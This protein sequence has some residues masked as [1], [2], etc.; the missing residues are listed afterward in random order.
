MIPI[1]DDNPTRLTPY[2]TW[3]L[4]L[5][6]VGVYIWQVQQGPD[7]KVFIDYG[8]MPDKLMS[9]Q[10]GTDVPAVAPIL[11]IFTSMF[12]HGGIWH[13]LGNMLY[14]WIFGNNIEDAMG[15]ARFLLF[16]VLSG[17]AAAM[18][19]AMMDPASNIPMVGA[20]GAISGVLGAY[21]L[22]YPRARVTVL[23]PILIIL[24]PFRISAVWVV[25]VWFAMQLWNAA[26]SMPNSPGVAWWAHVGGFAAGIALTPFLKSAAIPFFGPRPT[27]GPWG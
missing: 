14:L 15:H 17:V 3:A 5:A 7:S 19:M 24:Y 6:C 23:I 16:Y 18:T 25:G 13:L 22:L 1:S 20:S 27:R 8:F 10:F 4:I 2:V 26:V 12:L 21:M 9:P 11:T